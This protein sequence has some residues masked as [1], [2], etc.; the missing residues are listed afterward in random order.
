M[1]LIELLR[2]EGDDMSEALMEIFAPEIKTI[3]D[4]K[5]IAQLIITARI[6]GIKI[7]DA[8]LSM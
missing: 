3:T 5:Q 6:L 1:E 2:K 4:N 8:Y 7:L